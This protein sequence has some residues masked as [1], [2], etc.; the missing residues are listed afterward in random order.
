MRE[1]LEL[2]LLS[3]ESSDR[4]RRLTIRF[5]TNRIVRYE[6]S[7]VTEETKILHLTTERVRSR[8]GF[9]RQRYERE[10]STHP[11]G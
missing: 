7:S 5:E 4:S 8:Y 10:K 1:I 9:V 2:A 6:R 3:N 11:R